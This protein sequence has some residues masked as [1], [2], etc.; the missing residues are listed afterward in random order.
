MPII[1]SSR[2]LYRWLL[3][4]LFGALVFKLSVWCGAEGYVAGLRAA[5]AVCVC[6][7]VCA[8][9][10][11]R[12]ESYCIGEWSVD[13]QTTPLHSNSQASVRPKR[14]TFD[15]YHKFRLKVAVSTVLTAVRIRALYQS[16]DKSKQN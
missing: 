15:G 16:R 10:L 12:P 6:V 8:R 5:A 11:C 9:A 2:I 13:L 7:F 14:R 1:R 4:V 3:P